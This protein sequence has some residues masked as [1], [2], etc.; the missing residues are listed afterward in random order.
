MGERQER[1]PHIPTD[2][3]SSL[4]LIAAE[5]VQRTWNPAQAWQPGGA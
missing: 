3:R 2:V 4:L 1:S 5:V